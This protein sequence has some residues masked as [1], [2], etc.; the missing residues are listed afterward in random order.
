MLSGPFMHL[1]TI[2]HGWRGRRQRIEVVETL[3]HAINNGDYETVRK[4]VSPD[5]EVID[6]LGRSISG[7]EEFVAADSAFRAQVAG[8]QL[9]VESAIENDGDV[10]VTGRLSGDD[11][12]FA[13]STFWR[14]CFRGDLIARI[15]ITRDQSQMTVTKF[16]A[17]QQQRN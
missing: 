16:H 5:I 7:A 11:P 1:G 12:R 13:G 4:L 3:A 9:V 10:L 17:L 6:A 2:F 15:E 14:V 8:A